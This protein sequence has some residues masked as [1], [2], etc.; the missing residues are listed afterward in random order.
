[1]NINLFFLFLITGL[2]MIF[3]LFEPMQKIEKKTTEIPSLE[4]ND[5]KLSELDRYGLLSIVNGKTGAKYSNRYIV[6]DLDY[7]DNSSELIS[8]IKANTALYKG[9]V[10]D[11]QGDIKYFREDG[12]FFSTQKA[13]YN[14][15]TSIMISFTDYKSRQNEHTAEGSYLEYDSIKGITNSKDVTVNYKLRER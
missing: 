12:L 4:L 13:N 7:T 2:S 6:T 14:K 11:L 15:Q 8:N 10:L 3:F 9:F 5:F 1:M